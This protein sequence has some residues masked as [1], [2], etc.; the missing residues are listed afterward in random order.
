MRGG[1]PAPGIVGQWPAGARIEAAGVTVWCGQ[2]LG[3]LGARA[4]TGV[5]QPLRPQSL[6]RFGIGGGALRLDDRGAVMP[7]AEPF[8]VLEDAVD[9]LRTAAPGVQILDPQEELSATLAR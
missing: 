4:K 2:R 9:E 1:G 3:N 6:Q 7:E 8:Q 5:D